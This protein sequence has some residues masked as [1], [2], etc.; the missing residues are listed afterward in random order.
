[1]V[2]TVALL[3]SLSEASGVSGYEGPVRDLVRQAFEPYADEIRVD[4]LGNLIAL[5]RGTR[6]EGQPTR[7][8]MLAAHT[9]EIG[10]MVAGIEEG[11]SA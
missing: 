6:A 5:R 10:F 8:I 4:A 7:S 11:S 2:D 9:D 1:M 3:R